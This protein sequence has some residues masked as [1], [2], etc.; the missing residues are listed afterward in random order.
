MSITYAAREFFPSVVI[1]ARKKPPEANLQLRKKPPENKDPS[2]EEKMRRTLLLKR[3]WG[4]RSMSRSVSVATVDELKE[5][6][7]QGK[8][9]K[10]PVS[11][12]GKRWCERT[13]SWITGTDAFVFLLDDGSPVPRL[14]STWL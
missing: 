7:A 3:Q 10:F 1:T 13:K 14:G 6:R 9:K 8:V 12:E 11:N 2:E 5:L 4:C